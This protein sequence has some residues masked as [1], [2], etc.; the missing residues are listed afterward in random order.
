MISDRIIA[1]RN[2]KT[3]YRDGDSCI[4]C[5]GNGY[6]KADVLSE[7]LKQARVEEYGINVPKVREVAKIDG[8]W[9]IVSDYIK[10]K[11]LAEYMSESS[12]KI[13][14]YIK[15]LATLQT[16]INGFECRGLFSFKDKLA[17]KIMESG[18]P[19][20][21]RY[22]FYKRLAAM[23]N[24]E[25]LC[26]GDLEPSNVIID[27]EGVPFIIDWAHASY[28]DPLADAAKVYVSFVLKERQDLA[29]MYFEVFC[30]IGGYTL[31]NA[32]KWLPIVAAAGVACARADE[33][34]ILL[35]GFGKKIWE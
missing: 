26:H 8:N 32:K 33:R 11:S 6:S 1:V 16:E 28:G 10:G 2:D 29:K 12:E 19:A 3:V 13:D 9:A 18:L 22:D 4:K 27:S 30:G 25:R 20:T 21:M 15:L 35:K 31:D 24:P 34:E 23:P 7:A 14:E 5:F 17:E